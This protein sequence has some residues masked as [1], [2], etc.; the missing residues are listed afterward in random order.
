V[1]AADRL[2]L[3]VRMKASR[4]KGVLIWGAGGAL[5]AAV[6][7]DALAMIGRQLRLP[8][9]GSIEIVEAVVLIAASG[10]LIVATLD[11]AHARV[12]LLLE[13]MPERARRYCE[14]AHALVAVLL[15]A[16]LL[17]G[18]VWIAADLW[19]GHEES[20]LLR[21]PYRPLR[22][23]AAASLAGLLILSLR[24]LWRGSAQ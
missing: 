16:A 14:Q 24:N 17:A 8:L 15:F 6:A 22:I 12:R 19:H 4:L 13:R 1:A 2:D 9:L 7:V 21:I 23:V 3:D 10:A 20:E 5:L 11:A 18:T